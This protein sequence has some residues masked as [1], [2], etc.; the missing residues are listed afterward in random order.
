M[1][2]EPDQNQKIKEPWKLTRWWQ[3]IPK[4][5]KKPTHKS[6]VE[7]SANEEEIRDSRWQKMRDSWHEFSGRLKFSEDDNNLLNSITTYIIFASNLFQKIGQQDGRIPSRNY[8]IQGLATNQATILTDQVCSK[9]EE[10]IVA[11]DE[12]I[13]S[14][15]T[16]HRRESAACDSWQKFKDDMNDFYQRHYQSFSMPTA[17][18]TIIF[19]FIL[20]IADIPLSLALVG[21]FDIGLEYE[22][23]WEKLTDI[24][25]LTFSLG[26]AFSTI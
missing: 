26:I 22:T 25:L 2:N 4:F 15:A 24:E 13:S 10:R 21:N 6:P 11:A 1:A 20:M 12:M 19:G 23:I 9:L 18:L 14:L 16:A 17:V 5:F 8:A 7:S 3:S